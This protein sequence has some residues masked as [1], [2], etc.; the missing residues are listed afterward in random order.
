MRKIFILAFMILSLALN[1]QEKQAITQ[2]DYANTEVEMADRLR[3]DGKIYVVV[4][5]IT[6]LFL[7]LTTYMVILDRKMSRL[8]KELKA[9]TE[10]N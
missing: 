4:A 9:K 5:V 7:G 6:T 3:A 8:E 1:A 10:R 2:S